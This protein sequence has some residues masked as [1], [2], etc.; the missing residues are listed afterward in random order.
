MVAKVAD[1]RVAVAPRREVLPRLDLHLDGLVT[2]DRERTVGD[3]TEV[4]PSLDGV[5]R[6]P[7]DLVPEIE[8]GRENDGDSEEPVVYATELDLAGVPRAESVDVPRD[9]DAGV[10][11]RAL[12]YANSE[13]DHGLSRNRRARRRGRQKRRE[14]QRHVPCSHVS[15]ETSRN[16]HT[17]ESAPAATGGVSVE[18]PRAPW[19]SRA[20]AAFGGLRVRLYTASGSSEAPSRRPHTREKTMSDSVKLPE[21]RTDDGPPIWSTVRDRRSSRDYSDEPMSLENLSQLLWSTHGV[22][23]RRG[24]HAFRT[25]PSAGAC[26]PIDAYVVANR[27]RGL[28]AGLYRYLVG[29]HELVLMRDGEIGP[30]VTRAAVGQRMC[31]LAAVSFIWTAVVPR[32][33]GRYGERGHRYLFLDA[34]HVGQNLYLA[35]TALGLGVCT[36]AA[37]DDDAMNEIVGA[38]GKIETTVYAAVAGP[39]T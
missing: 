9:V 2:H 14:N 27:V 35:A 26:Y 23:G 3:G 34:G 10:R 15:H 13:G 24:G 29:S 20:R 4:G 17:P 38:D 36:I 22:T 11:R 7:R 1:D 21:P 18:R 30:E 8:S 33:T 19:P 28:P 31:E 6:P 16:E 25:S 39:V 12:R 5:P 32:T 37:F